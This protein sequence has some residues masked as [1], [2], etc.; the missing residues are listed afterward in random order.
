MDQN[1]QIEVSSLTFK[2]VKPA[3]VTE[4]T[5]TSALDEWTAILGTNNVSKNEASGLLQYCDPWG[6]TTLARYSPIAAVRPA[7]VENIQKIL[8]MVNNYSIPLWIVSRG[9]NLWRALSLL[10]R[11]DVERTNPD[12]ADQ[13]QP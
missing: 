4:A 5:F 3:G 10:V 8:F 2:Q 12:T 11:H 13:H 9:K 7:S 1:H 6:L